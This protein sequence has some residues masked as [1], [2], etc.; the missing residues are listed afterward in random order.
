MCTYC[1][2]EKGRERRVREMERGRER[3]MGELYLP[4]AA[5]TVLHRICPPST[6][7]SRPPPDQAG[8]Y[9]RRVHLV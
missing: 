6:G 1:R 3:E 4:T 9:R 7:S 8:L 5:A 2:S